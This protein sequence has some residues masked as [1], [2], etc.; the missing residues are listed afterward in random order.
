MF[1][2]IFWKNVTFYVT[3]PFTLSQIQDNYL[4]HGDPSIRIDSQKPLTILALLSPNFDFLCPPGASLSYP[5][6]VSPNFSRVTQLAGLDPSITKSGFA[7]GGIL[8]YPCAVSPNF[9]CVTQLAGIDPSI[10]T[11]SLS[12]VFR[13]S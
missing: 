1:I 4:S 6:A 12:Q 9:S 5:C 2:F 13:N 8:A 10:A 7:P 3:I 11:W